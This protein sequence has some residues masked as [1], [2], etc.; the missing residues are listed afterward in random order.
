MRSV[1]LAVAFDQRQEH[2]VQSLD[3]IELNFVIEPVNRFEPACDLRFFLVELLFGLE[4]GKIEG[5]DDVLL[6]DLPHLQM[7]FRVESAARHEDV[8]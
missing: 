3:G 5:S 8:I 1:G 2:L 6:H 7:L 4:N